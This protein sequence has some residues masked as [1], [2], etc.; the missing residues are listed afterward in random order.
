MSNTANNKRIAKNT[1]LLYFRMIL[2]MLVSFYTVRVV[3]NELGLVD[4]GLYNVVGGIVMMFSFFSDSMATTSQRFFSI[5]LGRNDKRQLK[6]I[7]SLTIIIYIA[8]S[9]IV[10]LLAETLGLWFLNT[11]MVIPIERIN[12]ANWIYQFSI[13]S[14]II[15][16]MT[17][18]YNATIIARENMS[19]YA[20]VSIIE[21][22]LKLLIVYL[23]VFFSIDKLKLYAVFMFIS[24]CIISIIYLIICI[25]KYEES[26]FNFYWNTE[27]FNAMFSFSA[28]KLI[29]SISGLFGNYG[30]NILL[31]IFFGP[32]VNAARAIS[33]QVNSALVSLSSS[34]YT[35]VRPQITKS[36][37]IGNTNHAL[38]LVFQSSKFSFYLIL[39]LSMPIILE[40]PF[41]LH[42]WLKDTTEYMIIF[43][44]LIIIFSL[45]NCLESPL[46][47]MVQATGKIKKYQIL[48]GSITLLSLPLSYTSFKLGYP[49]QI[50]LYILITVYFLAHF[51]RV[52]VVH[53]LV[54][55]SIKKY[56]REVIFVIVMV[57][58]IALILPITLMHYLK[59]DNL[60]R[61][62]SIGFSCEFSLLLTVYF[63]GLNKNERKIVFDFAK[64]SLF[65]NLSFF[66][67]VKP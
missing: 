46:S 21:V 63:I 39:L 41:L 2:T 67:K 25:R 33:Y 8:I 44:R 43:T 10:L 22:L 17:I 32:A 19:V 50:S 38:L 56:I 5:E 26:R 27:L 42:L 11:Q 23:L 61:F 60:Y 53:N 54:G 15:K 18:P 37:A 47:D 4:Y 6:Q 66:K 12:V 40:A 65:R 59:E 34:L 31:N 52:W 35:A 24:T 57:G 58:L 36:Y 16:I 49:P 28:W 3:F 30:L 62:I 64:K 51:L 9:V 1:I 55:M 48:I 29:G 14:F 13:L 20:Y 45:I 7:F